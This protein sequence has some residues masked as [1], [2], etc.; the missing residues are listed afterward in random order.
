M[1]KLNRPRADEQMQESRP[2]VAL[3]QWIR[4]F[5]IGCSSAALVLRACG[6][7]TGSNQ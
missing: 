6:S 1:F 4:K 5:R 3:R 2:V 7:T